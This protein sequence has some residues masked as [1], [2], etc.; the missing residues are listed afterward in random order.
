MKY[1]PMLLRFANKFAPFSIA[2]DIVHDVFMNVWGK[3]IFLSP[4][5]E[6]KKILYKAVQNAGIDYLRR[7]ALEQKFVDQQAIQLKL[8]ELDFYSSAE[9][10]FMRDDLMEH[11]HKQVNK[12]PERQRQIFY[13]FYSQGLQSNE[14]ARKLNLSVRTIENQLYRA[15]LILRKKSHA[16]FN[17]G[18]KS[19]RIRETETLF[20]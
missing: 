17:Y 1:A 9:H 10:L 11:L 3:K 18:T 8:K 12:L 7:L 15:R 6:I 4:D 2:E 20:E 14:I 16:Y 13:L 5:C 19:Q